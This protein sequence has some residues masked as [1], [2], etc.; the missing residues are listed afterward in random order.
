VSEN[1]LLRRIF[2][3][4]RD[5]DIGGWGKLYE[6]LQNLYSSRN[7]KMIKNYGSEMGWTYG[8]HGTD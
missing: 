3:P 7:I 1:R 6:K 2:G 5:E 4:E 8:M